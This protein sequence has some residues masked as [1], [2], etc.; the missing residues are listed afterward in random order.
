MP[1]LL[2]AI[3]KIRLDPSQSRL[4]HRQPKRCEPCRTSP[5]IGTVGGRRRCLR[6]RPPIA[7]SNYPQIRRRLSSPQPCLRLRRS[8]P[9]E[10]DGREEEN[11]PEQENGA[12][13]EE[14]EEEGGNEEGEAEEGEEEEAEENVGG[15]S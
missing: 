10:E 11:G 9:E 5:G 4:L 6:D 15:F 7:A 2:L 13:E 1:P 14:G 12:E 8:R 3:G